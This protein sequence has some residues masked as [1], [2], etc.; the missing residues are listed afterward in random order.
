MRNDRFEN[1]NRHRDIPRLRVRV[2]HDEAMLTEA[3]KDPSIRA[4]VLAGCPIA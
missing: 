4:V 3:A 1:F 2:A